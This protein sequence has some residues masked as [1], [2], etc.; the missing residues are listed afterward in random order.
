[1]KVV[2]A[3]GANLGD[4]ASTLDAAVADLAERGVC[5]SAVS[6]TYETDPVGGPDQPAYLNRV[7][8]GSTALDPARLIAVA[9]EVEALHGRERTVRWG[10]RTLDVDVVA[11]GDP[12]TGDD[13]RL[14]DGP[15]LLPHPRAR[16]RAF[17]LVPWSD[18]EPDAVLRLPDGRVE[19]V[20][21][22]ASA[23][24]DREG[25]RAWTPHPADPADHVATEATS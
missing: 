22:L 21:S 3:L 9:H 25:V 14:D 17:V 10:A 6:G 2:L 13:V 19:T 23:A 8:V 24:A 4:R 7:L 12:R 15:V 16:E 1:M 11:V 20:A 18:A 5:V